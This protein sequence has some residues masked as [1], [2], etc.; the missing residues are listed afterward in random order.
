[1]IGSVRRFFGSGRVVGVRFRLFNVIELV[2][3]FLDLF[4]EVVE[5]VAEHEP[6][7]LPLDIAFAHE[8]GVKELTHAQNVLVRLVVAS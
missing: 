7:F 6:H 3:E 1:M 8:L 2:L 5:F 4:V